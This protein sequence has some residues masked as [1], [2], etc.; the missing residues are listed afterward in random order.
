MYDIDRWED[1]GGTPTVHTPPQY[2]NSELTAAVAPYVAEWEDK[3]AFPAFT[4][5]ADH[6]R[7]F[8]RVQNIRILREAF[9]NFDMGTLA[10]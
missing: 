2:D 6:A 8:G 1:D 3:R 4:Y 9:D 5:A 7:E 10:P